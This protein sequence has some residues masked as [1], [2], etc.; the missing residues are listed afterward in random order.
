MPSYGIS[1]TLTPIYRSTATLLVNQTQ[2]PGTIAYNDILTSQRLTSTYK[3]L[4]EERARPSAVIDR[5]NLPLSNDQLAKKM[6]VTVVTDA[7]LLR[8]SVE[9]S[10]PALTSN[11]ANTAAAAF[12]DENT[13]DKLSRPGDVSIVEAAT[14]PRRQSS[15]T[16]EST[17]LLA[18]FVGLL[19]AGGIALRHRIPR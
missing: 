11:I 9:D 6:T 2:V 19:L 12:I 5:L 14:T 10:D 7:Q 1:K 15:R 3:E 4:I 13:Q 8:L 18:A 16:S 17:P